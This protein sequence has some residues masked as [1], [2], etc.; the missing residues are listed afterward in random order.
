MECQVELE[1]YEAG[2]ELIADVLFGVKLDQEKVS[3]NTWY[4][5]KKIKTHLNYSCTSIH[6]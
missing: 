5:S 6:R 4:N 3:R 2:I 1:K